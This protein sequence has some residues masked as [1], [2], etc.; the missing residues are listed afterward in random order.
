MFEPPLGYVVHERRLMRQPQSNTLRFERV[1]LGLY[2]TE[3]AARDGQTVV[4][5][6]TSS[7]L[8][9]DLRDKSH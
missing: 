8:N 5:V 2:G 7:T 4:D 6:S 3:P 1:T 9:D